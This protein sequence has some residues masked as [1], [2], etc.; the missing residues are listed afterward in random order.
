MLGPS[1]SGSQAQTLPPGGLT[2]SV[3]L[4][5]RLV[6]LLTG[7]LA[8]LLGKADGSTV[9]AMLVRELSLIL[10]SRHWHRLLGIWG[11]YCTGVLVLPLLFRAHTQSWQFPTGPDWALLCGY[12]LQG[13]LFFWMA[14]W[15]I[16]RLR[17]DL[18][19]DRLDELMLTRCSPADIAMGEATASAVA[20]LWLVAVSFP[21]CL[22]LAAMAGQGLGSAL[23]LQLTLAPAGV[24]GVWFGMGWGLA[25]TLRRGAMVP[26]TE[27][28]LKGPFMP[29]VVIWSMLGFFTIIG[30]LLG[31]VPGGLQALGFVLAILQ[32]C[33]RQIAQHGNPL[34]AVG[35]SF[36]QWGT[37]WLTDWLVLVGIAVF[38]MRKSMDAV[39]GSLATLPER[40]VSRRT[41]EAWVHHDVH[42]FMQYGSEERRRPNYR[43]G[44]NPIAA[45]DVALGHRVY[46]HPFLW[47]LA[48][49][50]Y[51]FL[52]GWSLL[53]PKMGEY[54]AIAAVLLPATGSLLLM[55]GGVAVSFGW[56]RDQHRWPALAGLP[57][58]N[59]SLAAG[60]IKGVVRPMLW[61]SLVSSG[62]AVLL[63]WR[64]A[65]PLESS[66]WMALHVLIFPSALACLSAVLALST[67]TLEEAL[68]RWAVLGAIPTL[69]TMLPPPIGGA[70][71]L[72]LPFTPPLL[73]LLLVLHGPTPELVRS[74]WIS[75][76]L[77]IFGTVASLL[78][79]KL[80]LRRWTVGEKD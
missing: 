31:F 66:Y 26:L 25:F 17:K 59:L 67:P 63:G 27:W 37:F 54:T 70:S 78:I 73:A 74:S 57:L 15:T 46:L 64:G 34:L 52:V 18:Y 79:L 76:G 30:G 49:M 61:V 20:S 71:G 55:S 16:R 48:I 12:A 1:A 60:K 38:M 7:L 58:D 77:Q 53:V 9:A 4:R 43:D 2:P 23:R 41:G 47:C 11:V 32:W 29:I 80:L 68:Y 45:F 33:A 42:H 56:E 6:H 13:G 44:G 24:L 10:R 51:L 39:Q 50:A 35:A 62:T 72:A 28:W 21:V 75:L 65:M 69:A 5:T 36:G 14:Q 8:R 22:L 3:R 40:D 19:T